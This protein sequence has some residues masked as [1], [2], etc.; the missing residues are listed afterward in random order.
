MDASEQIDPK[1]IVSGGNDHLL[2]IWKYLL[3]VFSLKQFYREE[4]PDNWVLDHELKGHSDWVRD[5]A[6]APSESLQHSTIA[7][8]GMV[9]LK[10]KF[11]NELILGWAGNYLA[12]LKFRRK[13]MDKPCA[14]QI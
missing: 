1:R 2:K 9:H 12:L 6:W 10:I 13:K 3:F 4:S 11:L 7:S 5:V 8:C 14:G